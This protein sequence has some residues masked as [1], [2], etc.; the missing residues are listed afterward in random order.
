MKLVNIISAFI[1]LAGFSISFAEPVSKINVNN[2][3]R[4]SFKPINSKPK[5]SDSELSSLIDDLNNLTL[6]GERPKRKPKQ[7]KP[8]T[9]TLK[10]PKQVKPKSDDKKKLNSSIFAQLKDN[11]PANMIDALNVADNLFAA[12]QKDYA[13]EIYKLYLPKINDDNLKS[14][15]LYQLGC[16]LE[17]TDTKTSLKYFNQLIREFPKSGWSKTAKLKLKMIRWLDQNRPD[18]ILTQV[19]NL[20]NKPADN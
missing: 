6:P 20:I 11:L 15:V 1:L 7:A 3:L 4:E 9:Q 10:T 13:F 2:I 17:K 16:C 8:A 12:N 19:E 18:E 14:W 5:T